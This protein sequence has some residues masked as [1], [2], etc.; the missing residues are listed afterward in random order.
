MSRGPDGDGRTGPEAPHRS[1]ARTG[2][3]E[4]RA[5]GRHSGEVPGAAAVPQTE[6]MT[7]Q[8]IRK[9]LQ[10]RG[11]IHGHQWAV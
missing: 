6:V 10:P 8:A 5:N 11:P 2:G 1:G 4:S 7:S 9:T 3:A